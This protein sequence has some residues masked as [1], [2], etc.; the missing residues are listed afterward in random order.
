MTEPTPYIPPAKDED[1]THYNVQQFPRGV[2]NFPG[3]T[4][5][6]GYSG[7]TDTVEI[8]QDVRGAIILPANT[9]EENGNW[10]T[11][12]PGDVPF[13]RADSDAYPPASDPMWAEW[14]IT[15]AGKWHRNV[16]V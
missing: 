15:E 7:P 4:V 3:T 5:N 10:W 12:E 6:L 2:H 13:F 1:E 8:W 11:I 14:T 16:A 9:P